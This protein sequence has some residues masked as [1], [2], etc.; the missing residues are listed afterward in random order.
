MCSYLTVWCAQCTSPTGIRIYRSC[1]AVSEGRRCTGL[2][3]AGETRG[4]ELCGDCAG[5]R[6]AKVVEVRW[7]EWRIWG[8]EVG[9]TGGGKILLPDVSVSFCGLAWFLWR[10]GTW[11]N[12][13]FPEC[14]AS[15][16]I[17][18]KWELHSSMFFL[19]YA[20]AVVNN[21]EPLSPLALRCHLPYFS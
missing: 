11:S 12:Q 1:H 20:L 14:W 15:R 2:T 6:W 17:C 4:R 19:H 16:H 8:D 13:M 5:R 21:E 18:H 10:R 3:Q 7:R 9:D